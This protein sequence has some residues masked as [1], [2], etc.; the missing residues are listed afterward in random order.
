MGAAS[1]TLSSVFSN[2]GF[3]P[4][5]P[6]SVAPGNV[7]ASSQLAA[8][9]RNVADAVE[10]ERRREQKQKQRR[11]LLC[12]HQ[13]EEVIDPPRGEILVPDRFSESGPDHDLRID[14]M[15]LASSAASRGQEEAF[16]K[17]EPLMKELFDLQDLNKN[18]FLEEEELVKLNE[19]ITMLHYGKDQTDRGAVKQQYKELFRE[20]LDPNGQPVSFEIFRRYMLDRLDEM[21][22]DRLAQELILEQFIAEAQSGRTAFHCPSFYSVTDQPYRAKIEDAGPW[23]ES[24]NDRRFPATAG[25]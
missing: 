12:M 21:D 7:S 1:N 14:S 17:M 5:T 18:G 10:Y 22:R 11:Y 15:K 23:A 20:K 16:Q 25:A 19:K 6:C 9:G 24:K 13:D 8:D 4:D 3:V 2:C